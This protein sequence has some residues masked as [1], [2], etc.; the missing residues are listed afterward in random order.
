MEHILFVVLVAIAASFIGI[1]VLLVWRASCRP[2]SLLEKHEDS[3][4]FPDGYSCKRC[5]RHYTVYSLGPSRP[6]TEHLEYAYGGND[7]RCKCLGVEGQPPPLK[8]KVTHI[9]QRGSPKGGTVDR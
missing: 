6:E 9:I 3:W 8:T 4:G 7:K 5:G 1:V 2:I